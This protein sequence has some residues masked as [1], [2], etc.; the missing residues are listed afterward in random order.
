M[1]TTPGGGTLTPVTMTICARKRPGRN[2]HVCAGSFSQAVVSPFHSLATT[3]VM[4]RLRSQRNQGLK[5]LNGFNKG[6]LHVRFSEAMVGGEALRHD[7]M[8]A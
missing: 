3:C 1:A 6:R 8:H 5:G 7:R 4:H 2:S